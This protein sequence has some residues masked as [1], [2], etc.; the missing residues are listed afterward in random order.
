MALYFVI[1]CRLPV[2]SLLPRKRKNTLYPLHN[3]QSMENGLNVQSI[4][5]KPMSF[6]AKIYQLLG[7]VGQCKKGA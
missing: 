5:R 2:F 6:F 1:R 4:R 7:F 3:F